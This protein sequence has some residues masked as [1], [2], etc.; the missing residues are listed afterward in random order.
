MKRKLINNR[1]LSLIGL[2]ALLNIGCAKITDFG[3]TNVNPNGSTYASTSTLLSAVEIRLGNNNYATN[4]GTTSP[5]AELLS[6]LMAQYFSEYT[7]PQASLY[8]AASFQINSTGIYSGILYDVQTIINRNS[9]PALA[10]DA[11]NYGSN[12]SQLAIARILKAM[13]FWEITDKWGDMPYSEALKGT[14]NLNPK[15]DTQESIYKDLI[16]ELTEAVAQ[17]SGANNVQGDIIYNG[18]EAKWKKLANSLRMLISLRMS[19]RYP[20][21]GDYAATEFRKAISDVAGYI[22]SN[23]DNM[24]I[25]YPGNANPYNNPYYGPFNSNDNAASKTLTDLLAGLSDNRSNAFVTNL[26]GVP[27]GLGGPAPAGNWARTLSSTFKQAAGTYV[28]INAASVL[29]AKAEAIQIGWVTDPAQGTAQ[30]AYEAGV[31]A[32]FDQWGVSL[33]ASYLTSGPANFTS[34]AGV[35][36]IGGSTVPGSN[37]ITN[38]PLKRIQLQQYLAWYP[39]GYQAWCNWRRT[40]FPDLRPTINSTTPGDQIARRLTYGTSEYSLNLAQLNVAIA[41]IGA[42]S[43]NTKVWWDQ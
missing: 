25:Y 36:S 5:S 3:N 28:K 35:A 23:A 13:I 42:D 16:K 24:G 19:K 7:Y 10:V 30:A 14:A 1:F 12:A 21:T 2:A 17:F 37:A 27:Y 15:Y 6:G 41:R 4:T 29:L 38:T 20:A 22:S 33:P 31:A 9:D 8:A 26:N 43:K 40:G 11:A 39:I 34:G 32:S 18:N